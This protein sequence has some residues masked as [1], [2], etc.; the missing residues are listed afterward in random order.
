MEDDTRRCGPERLGVDVAHDGDDGIVA[1]R[2]LDPIASRAEEVFDAR[3]RRARRQLGIE[4]LVNLVEPRVP[5]VRM[6]FASAADERQHHRCERQG[7]QGGRARALLHETSTTD[8]RPPDLFHYFEAG[9]FDHRVGE[10][11]SGNAL[12]LLLRLVSG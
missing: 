6:L 9:F 10:H 3:P 5:G 1:W 11:L 8:Y 12:K 2:V 4:R 7:N